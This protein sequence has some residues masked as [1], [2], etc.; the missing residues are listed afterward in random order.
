MVTLG[1]RTPGKPD[2]PA[3]KPKAKPRSKAKTTEKK[4]DSHSAQK[5]QRK[6]KNG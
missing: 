3:E 6:T 1:A 2:T 5:K 4:P